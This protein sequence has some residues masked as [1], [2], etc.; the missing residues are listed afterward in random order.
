M[1]PWR[2]QAPETRAI[3]LESTPIL[4]RVAST[5]AWLVQ[6]EVHQM[7]GHFRGAVQDARGRTIAIERLLGWVEDHRAA[8]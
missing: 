2:I 6:S 8:W 7:L 3:D 5:R 1:K 4:E